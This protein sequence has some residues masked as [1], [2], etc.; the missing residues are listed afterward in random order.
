MWRS[1]AIGV[2]LAGG[3]AGCSWATGGAGSQGGSGTGWTAYPISGT[4]AGQVV[5]SGGIQFPL[6][7]KPRPATNTPLTFVAIPATG[8]M[9][10]KH[11]K[12]DGKGRFLVGLAPGRYRVGATFTSSEPLAQAAR[13]L[14]IVRAGRMEHV[15]LIEGVR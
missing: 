2:V 14:I 10:V 9:V 3:L 6:H 1:V 11:L 13:K 4:V 5:A 12:T 7:K 8:R 15:R